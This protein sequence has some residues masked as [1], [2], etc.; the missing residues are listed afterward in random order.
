MQI[1]SIVQIC[2]PPVIS[3]ETV[4]ELQNAIEAHLHMFKD[5]FPHVNIT[6]KMHYMLHIPKQIL[7]LGPLVRHS[8][9]RFEAK[10][11]YFKDLAPQQNY[12]NIC[13]SLAE[14]CQLDACADFET[15]KLC[16]HPLFSTE[17]KLGPP[18]SVVDETRMAFFEKIADTKIF[19][20]PE[21]LNKLFLY[22]WIELYGTRYITCKCCIIAV[23]A[24]FIT[25]MPVFG[26]LQRIWL[27]DDEIIFEIIQLKTVQFNPNLLA[28]EVDDP[29]DGVPTR[30][31]LYKKMLDFNVYSLQYQLDSA[32]VPIRYDLK[33]VISQQVVG[34]HPLHF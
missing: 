9:I 21:R 1:I 23:D 6:L 26:R 20:N 33:D 10:H 3:E 34:E 29:G 16:Q 25:R 2:F 28:Y 14:R 15:E 12:K 22:K 5:L 30:F 13:L 8:C 27:V 4:Q 24:T 7:N 19:S 18:S 11:R 31:V 17:K 32:Y